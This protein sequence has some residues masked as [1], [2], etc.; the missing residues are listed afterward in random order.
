[1]LSIAVI[2]A[3]G[4]FGY[5]RKP[6]QWVVY[7]TIAAF[8]IAI[9]VRVAVNARPEIFGVG[10]MA[11]GPWAT[12]V[13]LA[14]F[15]LGFGAYFAGLWLGRRG[16]APLENAGTAIERSKLFAGCVES[17]RR[18]WLLHQR[19][20]PLDSLAR[21]LETFAL[22]GFRQ[23]RESPPGGSALSVRQTWSLLIHSVGLE[24]SDKPSFRGIVE[25]LGERYGDF[26][27]SPEERPSDALARILGVPV[28]NLN[29]SNPPSSNRYLDQ[30]P[31]HASGQ[32][33]PGAVGSAGLTLRRDGDS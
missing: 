5:R 9:L 30:N 12:A 29:L 16:S 27:V 15:C 14:D 13:A 25:D 22:L 3:C 7:L 19:K 31:D 6:L 20:L 24:V 32:R 8:A 26:T 10:S 33:R 21:Q 23:L 1:M 11:L 4:F 28:S 2:I 18:E 17:L